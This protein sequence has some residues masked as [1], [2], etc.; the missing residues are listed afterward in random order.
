MKAHTYLFTEEVNNNSI[1]ELIKYILE[2]IT[3]ELNKDSLM[4]DR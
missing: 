2:I 4:F 1:N 3:A